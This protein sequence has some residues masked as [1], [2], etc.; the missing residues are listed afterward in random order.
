MHLDKSNQNLTDSLPRWWSPI[1]WLQIVCSIWCNQLWYWQNVRPKLRGR[2]QGWGI[3]LQ[4]TVGATF[5]GLILSLVIKS[6][7]TLSE[8]Q[9][10]TFTYILGFTMGNF[11]GITISGLSG[12]LIG[13][14]TAVPRSAIFII[15][16]TPLGVLAFANP[17]QEITV[18]M[19]MFLVS[20][21]VGIERCV[22]T[23]QNPDLFLSIGIIISAVLLQRMTFLANITIGF[24]LGLGFYMGQ[25]WGDRQVSDV[26]VRQNLANPGTSNT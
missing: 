4:T 26:V 3:F 15:L 6:V 21:A 18:F 8:T 10:N 22:I 23:G 19:G 2:K 12:V 17:N 7:L 24:L 1:Q 16:S 13:V 25:R 20:T 11:T 5:I 9:V 14:P